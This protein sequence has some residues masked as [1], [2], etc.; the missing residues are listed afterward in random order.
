[1]YSK[2]CIII[3]VIYILLFLLLSLLLLLS[4]YYYYSL[5]VLFLPRFVLGRNEM[6]SIHHDCVLNNYSYRHT[7]N[8]YFLIIEIKMNFSL[9]NNRHGFYI[10]RIS[11]KIEKDFEFVFK[12]FNY[13]LFTY[14]CIINMFTAFPYES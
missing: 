11:K 14:Y 7:R 3:Y 8:L 1:M 9:C 6:T 5:Y 13:N 2:V 10:P 4:L 12:Q